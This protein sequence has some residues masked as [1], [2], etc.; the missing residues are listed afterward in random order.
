MVVKSY[1]LPH[2]LH[3]YTCIKPPT[4]FNPRA[5]LLEEQLVHCM[6]YTK[7]KRVRLLKRQDYAFSDLFSTKIANNRRSGLGSASLSL[8]IASGHPK[9]RPLSSLRSFPQFSL[10]VFQVRP[11]TPPLCPAYHDSPRSFDL[12]LTVKADN[13]PVLVDGNV[14]RSTDPPP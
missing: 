9:R 6:P 11:C 5:A 1:L 7:S 12:N 14:F 13:A 4:S 8:W 3:L 10:C 2:L